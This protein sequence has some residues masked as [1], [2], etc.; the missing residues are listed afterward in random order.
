AE[1]TAYVRQRTGR[2]NLDAW[3]AGAYWTHYGPQ[4]WYLNAVIQGT[5]YR[6]SA[7]TA[8]ARLKTNGTGFV[9][10]LEGGY[11]IPLPQFGTSFV[12]EPQAQVLGQWTDF[13]RANDGLGQVALGSTS[14]GAARAGLKGTWS[15]A[16]ESGQI[17][18]T[19][20]RIDYWN[21]WGGDAST[22]Y[23]GGGSSNSIPTVSRAQYMDVGGG[24]TTQF[25]DHLSGFVDMGYQFTVGNDGNGR[26]K[27]LKGFIGL[28]YQFR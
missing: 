5:N 18:Q 14:G 15:L 4:G 21:E 28:R 19:Y 22:R 9:A 2:V 27:G 16:G 7:R 3:S 8:S 6:G 10:S 13:N 17:G 26:R 24:L 23:S 25:N 20:V 11:P 1:T 12:L